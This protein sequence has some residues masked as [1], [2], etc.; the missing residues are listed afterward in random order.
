MIVDLRKYTNIPNEIYEAAAK[1]D[2][3][4]DYLGMSQI[5]DACDRRL[6]YA[7]NGY[8]PVAKDGRIYLI[9]ELGFA[10]EDIIIKNLRKAGYEIS[11]TQTEF[12]DF[13][14]KFKG[15][16]DGIIYGVTK[17]P[18]ILEC[19]SANDNKFNQFKKSGIRDVSPQYYCQAQCYM[20]YSGLERALFVIYNKN[21]SEIYAERIYFDKEDFEMLRARA[22]YILES[23]TPPPKY[24]EDPANFECRYCDYRFEC[25]RG[26]I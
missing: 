13:D 24:D 17:K 20:G 10:I 23:T 21:T 11:D 26:L 18:H 6:W 1:S 12:E 22:K 15:H 16:C 8:M 9:F 14:G 7:I 3:P 2:K 25:H 4:R 19:K 5:G